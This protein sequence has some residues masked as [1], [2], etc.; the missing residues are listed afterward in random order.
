MVTNGTTLNK[1]EVSWDDALGGTLPDTSH[2]QRLQQT[3]ATVAATM[4]APPYNTPPHR[5]AM[6]DNVVKLVAHCRS[7]GTP[8][9]YITTHRRADNSDAPKTVSD[10]GGG[11]GAM[12]AGTPAVQV[13]DELALRRFPSGKRMNLEMD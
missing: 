3:V 12:L 13:V 5:Q 4:D 10:I 11:G 7:V 9:I 1:Q 6:L 2:Q 8:L